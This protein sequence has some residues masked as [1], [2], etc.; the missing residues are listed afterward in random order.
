MT[1][2]TGRPA[3]GADTAVA[4]LASLGAILSQHGLRTRLA[5]QAGTAPALHVT[6]PEAAGLREQIRAAPLEGTWRYWWSWAEPIPG[7]TARAA[8][9]IRR[10]LRTIPAAGAR[11]P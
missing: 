6:S 8:D 4:M 7:D 3:A 11:Q 10:V 9:A 2:S 1:S 5:I